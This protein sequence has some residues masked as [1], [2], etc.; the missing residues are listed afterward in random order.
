MK[1]LWVVIFIFILLIG[2]AIT[3]LIFTTSTAK[4]VES[5]IETSL[6]YYEQ[7]RINES[8][9]AIRMAKETWKENRKRMEIFLIHDNV[10]NVTYSLT[11]AEQMLLEDIDDFPSECK[12]AIE[13][14]NALRDI[15]FPYIENIL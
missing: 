8:L 1:R 9:I 14:L 4:S 12:K 2:L 6:N 15:Q 13:Q 7:H 10:H 3:E 5:H 11:A